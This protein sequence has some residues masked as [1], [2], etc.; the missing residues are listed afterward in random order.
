MGAER[1]Y[2][3]LL[4]A[5][6]WLAKNN[7]NQQIYVRCLE[8]A[9]SCLFKL[10]YFF[11]SARLSV[12]FIAFLLARLF[13]V[14]QNLWFPCEIVVNEPQLPVRGD[15]CTYACQAAN[16]SGE[17]LRALN[18]IELGSAT[19]IGQANATGPLEIV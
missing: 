5:I 10:D 11:C 6:S 16:Y 9:A 15:V 17:H 14:A 4:I 13:Y 7:K 12:F 1:R 3:F 8:V 19:R 18:S 2:F